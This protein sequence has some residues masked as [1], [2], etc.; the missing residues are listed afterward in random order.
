MVMSGPTNAPDPAPPNDP[1]P[2]RRV[3]G[4]ALPSDDI[5]WQR[6][7]EVLECF[8]L[9]WREKGEP[10]IEDFLPAEET[11]Q[12]TPLLAELIKIDL[13]Y[14]WDRGG[15]PKV[16][17][18]LERF[19]ELTNSQAVVEELIHEEIQVRSHHG[20]GPS[21]EEL[22]ER[23]PNWSTDDLLSA[24]ATR[25]LESRSGRWIGQT[26]V[27]ARLGRYEVR[28][29]QG[30][31]G[32]ATV[33]RGWDPEL[34]RE[35][36]I[37]VPRA[38][39]LA[40]TEGQ[41]R[42][43]REATSAARLRH[44][45]IV[46]I[47]ET[48]RQGDTAFIVFEF[49]PGP[50]LAEVLR[51]I[52]PTPRQAA[53]WV[54]RIADAL[55]Y[56]HRRGIVHRDVKPSNVLMDAE[57]QPLLSDFGLAFYSEGGPT[58]TQ[59]GDLLGTP[60]YMSPEQARGQSHEVD[61]RTDV[62]SLGVL[63]YELLCGRLPFEGPGHSVLLQVLHDEPSTPRRHRTEI[64]ADLE[65][66]CLKAM[67]KEPRR[68]YATAG[69]MADD[70]RRYLEHRPIQA[71]RIGPLGRFTRWCRRRP[72]LAA[73]IAVALVTVGAVSAASVWQII[74]ERNH[75][76]IARDSAEKNLYRALV[77]D[78]RA[79]LRA[80][81]TAWWWKAMDN[82]REAASLEVADK[83]TD[84]LRELALECM[85]TS[86][87][88]FRLRKTW[89]G[90]DGAIT[91][92]AFSPDGSRVVSG[93]KDNSVRLWDA[94]TGRTLAV[95][96]GHA[97]AVTGVAYHP[98]G[99][100]VASAS[101]DGTVRI[102][103][104]ATAVKSPT[105]K[106][107]EPATGGAEAPTPQILRLGSAA[108][109]AIAFSSDGQ[110]LA[111]ACGAHVYLFDAAA[112][113]ILADRA[114]DVR[115]E[116][117]C[118]AFTSEGKRVATGA[119][120]KTLRIWDV[121]SLQPIITWTTGNVPRTITFD[122]G[123]FALFCADAESFRF[124]VRL[125]NTDVFHDNIPLHTGPVRQVFV[126]GNSSLARAV[127]ASDD[128]TLKV[129][130]DPR[131]A[132]EAAVARGGFR[133]VL[134][135]A[136]DP[137]GHSIVA[138]HGDGLIRI[139]ELALPPQH[140]PY[141]IS[142]NVA[143]IGDQHRLACND[144]V[145]DVSSKSP[146]TEKPFDV[147]PVTALVTY[148]D[149]IRFAAARESCELFVC[150]AVAHRELAHWSAHDLPITG[151][152]LDP[153]G[154]HL[155]SG[156]LDGQ[157]RI[158]DADTGRLGISLHADV[159]AVHQVAWSLD[160]HGLAAAGE[161]GAVL[162][163]VADEPSLSAS[164]AAGTE[165]LP[166][167][168]STPETNRGLMPPA[169]L[170][171]HTLPVGV[172]A[173][174]PERLVTSCA[175]GTI[176]F[177][178]PRS[179]KVT[180]KFQGHT[181]P[182]LA[183]AFSPGGRWMAS[184]ALDRTIRLWETATRK[185][186]GR[187]TFPDRQTGRNATWLT[188]HRDGRFLMAGGHSRIGG[189]AWTNVWDIQTLATVAGAGNNSRAGR[190]M[191]D[192][193]GVLVANPVGGVDWYALKD[194][195]AAAKATL[196]RVREAPKADPIA[197]VPTIVTHGGHTEAVWGVAA[198][199]DDRWVATA[200]HDKTVK[201]WD[202]QTLKLVRTLEPRESL[203][204]CVAFSPDSKYVA[205][206][207]GTVRVWE[208]DTG[209][210]IH[211]FSG[212]ERLIV[213]VAFHPMQPW[214]VSCSLDGAVRLWDLKTGGSLGLL[215]QFDHAVHNLAFR[216]DGRWLAAACHDQNVALWDL[217]DLSQPPTPRPP[218]RLLTGHTSA[219]WAVSFSADGRWF[220]S[221]ADEGAIIL[222]DA[223]TFARTATLKAGIGQLRCVAFSS[224]GSLLA[225]S[226]AYSIGPDLSQT[227]VWD[228]EAVRTKLRE[229]KLDW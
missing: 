14:R 54:A 120:D 212:H 205:S 121:A 221:G 44:P 154:L 51:R 113:T 219:V 144:R 202:T 12:R 167:A 129:W 30:R 199:A 204:W 174:G 190:F 103:N 178:N 38:E 201:L 67:S 149:S 142:H 200:S 76:R 176:E 27:P 215:H 172:V 139:W 188:F 158:W 43:L 59:E 53:E 39:L 195:E 226:G 52:N 161:R 209:R 187:F 34:R 92:I 214:L 79:Q 136:S 42:L 155:A 11:A 168:E 193:S 196:D 107:D 73:T 206:G 131:R 126:A 124:F 152:A 60:A 104:V 70:L 133:E 171:D 55:D 122:F 224:D 140:M 83:N 213:S 5:N 102:W 48:G 115:A 135:A 175:D 186:L 216:P 65:T 147:S 61:A 50:S 64:P 217:G 128:G 18:Y 180:D 91:G 85:G 222:W 106:A 197:V 35:V 127:T 97:G 137:S 159:G 49:V 56:A 146:S 220:A 191:P 194:I 110:R 141:R 21:A 151:L 227:I 157:V 33:Y 143:F 28:E 114:L 93:S 31:G 69:D 40:D 4:S 24:M 166:E 36:A 75:L 177:R 153:E 78:A 86:Y 89:E 118:L 160:G 207:S 109:S 181:A 8:E 87:P 82:I 112:P 9:A 125:V 189:G 203:V 119:V 134:C 145:I 74:Q 96:S 71:R 68:R 2:P 198:S 116:V 13:E 132:T 163:N 63:L 223:A 3:D 130:F 210:E 156:S 150:D 185:E 101:A 169:R 84:E 1:A 32:C 58:L 138:G 192:G 7:E 62:Y 208:V 229:M 228:I 165:N 81:D 45:A 29:I 10:R 173:F 6:S 105:A 95:L 23:F 25:P 100:R 123:D 94:A 26:R 88:C 182:L 99:R 22:R 184:S 19:G 72:A 164:P 80:R 47:Y 211:S 108:V 77:S 148:P 41:A 111:A 225:G 15:R 162:W 37:K 46:P 57:G 170:H 90:H 98:D 218:D 179:G 117:T 183:V 66:I 16:E 17:E 20:C